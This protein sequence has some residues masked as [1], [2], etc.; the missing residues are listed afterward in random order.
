MLITLRHNDEVIPVETLDSP[1]GG[2]SSAKEKEL[3][4]KLIEALAGQ[5]EPEAY[6]DRYQD[7]VRKLI[8]CQTPGQKNKVEARASKVHERVAHGCTAQASRWHR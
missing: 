3:A 6:H 1:Q 5:F 2:S 7:K 4:V 8:C